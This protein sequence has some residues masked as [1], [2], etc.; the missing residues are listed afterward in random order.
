MAKKA[1]VAFFQATTAPTHGASVPNDGTTEDGLYIPNSFVGLRVMLSS[2]ANT[3]LSGF[4]PASGGFSPNVVDAAA[5]TTAV[6]N[7][8]TQAVQTLAQN[9]VNYG[10]EPSAIY[11][12]A[13]A[14][15]KIN[16][17]L[18]QFVRFTS[19][20]VSG[21]LVSGAMVRSIDTVSGELPLIIIPGNSIGTYTAVGG[22][23]NGILCEDIY[24]VDET[25]MSLPF[26]GSAVPTTIEIPM[27]FDRTLVRRYIMFWMFGLAMKIPVF[28]GK[29]R[30]IV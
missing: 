3:V 16:Q 20:D 24:V 12:S 27:G 21:G 26:L 15:G 29:V 5:P 23:N 22:P 2:N 17:E 1:Q 11:L 28:N 30:A 9:I 14:A 13:R 18:T 8:I 19:S 25:T 4:Y 10:G 6:T 7:P